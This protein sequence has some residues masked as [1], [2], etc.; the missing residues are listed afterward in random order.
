MG[1]F[2]SY[3]NTAAINFAIDCVCQSSLKSS[4]SD[5]LI[6]LS[7]EVPHV[8]LTD[9]LGNPCVN[10]KHQP[11]HPAMH[12]ILRYISDVCYLIPQRVIDQLE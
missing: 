2:F 11:T 8:T 7:P 9:S 1:L 10:N 6:Y 12:Y 3:S 5:K 4:N